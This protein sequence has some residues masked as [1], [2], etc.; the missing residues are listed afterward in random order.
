VPSAPRCRIDL[1]EGAPGVIY[2]YEALKR[3]TDVLGG[4]LESFDDTQIDWAAADP[5]NT[6]RFELRFNAQ[7]S[8]RMRAYLSSYGKPFRL[9]CDGA[10]LFVG[11][12][13]S[14]EGAAALRTPVLHIQYDPNRDEEGV[15]VLLGAWQGAWALPSDGNATLRERIDRSEF[16]A[17]LCARGILNEL[18]PP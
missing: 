10:E 1:L 14:L 11:V 8:E 15:V 5:P 18:E 16:R 7:G 3:H 4:V 17:A 13:Y 9:S 6:S 2:E 12:I